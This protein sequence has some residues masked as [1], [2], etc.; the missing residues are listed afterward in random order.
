MNDRRVRVGITG[1]TGL[2]LVALLLLVSHFTAVAGPR[3]TAGAEQSLASPAAFSSATVWSSGWVPIAQGTCRLFNHNLG[4]DPN[5]YVVELWF[6]DTDEGIGINRAN[7]GGMELQGKWHGGHWQQLTA[8]TI[9][10]CRQQDDRAADRIYVRVS[11]PPN[12]PEYD[13]GWTDLSIGTTVFTHGLGIAPT[14]LTVSLWFSGTDRGIHQFAYGGLALDLLQKRLGGHWSNL[15][16]DTVRVTRHLDDTDV[17]QVRVV[18]VHADR[19]AYDSLEALAGWQPIAPHTEFTIAHNLNWNPTMML[20]RGE[21]LSSTLGIHHL[22]S[23][24]NHDW[25]VGMQGAHLQN[26]TDSAV[27]F[28]RRPDDQVCPQFRVRIWKRTA[29]T[30]LPLVVRNL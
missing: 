17:E 12:A 16:E 19:P 26:L 9:R 18:V 30:Y 21:C 6:L 27:R 8:S 29:R 2:A 1:M 7:Y 28:I 10:V 11:I 25:F 22:L 13:S 15:T 14:D 20:V 4:A 23:G 5:D 3:P 24:G